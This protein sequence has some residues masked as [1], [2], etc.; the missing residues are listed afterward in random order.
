MSSFA[1]NGVVS[2]GDRDQSRSLSCGASEMS[3]AFANG[4][5]L[6]FMTETGSVESEL[7][8]PDAEPIVNLIHRLAAPGGAVSA[9]LYS[10]ATD[11]RPASILRRQQDAMLARVYAD[12]VRSNRVFSPVST[13][14]RPAST[15]TRSGFQHLHVAL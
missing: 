7:S 12:A 11:S 15:C 6:K 4:A 1:I 2:G 8:P 13:I 5:R 10:M 9:T 3:A 14:S